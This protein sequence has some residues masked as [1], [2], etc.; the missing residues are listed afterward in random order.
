MTAPVAVAAPFAAGAHGGTFGDGGRGGGDAYTDAAAPYA[1]EYADVLDEDA[2]G[3]DGEG[4][5][6]TWDG[7]EW[8]AWSGW[9]DQTTNYRWQAAAA[10]YKGKHFVF[11]D[12]TDN[13]YHAS[14]HDG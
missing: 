9:N 13:T 8:S 3:E 7:Q 6:T 12:G 14:G 5:C 4:S 2:T 1:I 11:Y 10:E